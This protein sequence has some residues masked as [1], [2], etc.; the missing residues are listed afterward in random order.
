MDLLLLI[1][2]AVLF[3]GIQ[4]S[5][6]NKDY[7]GRDTTTAIKGIF[8]IIILFSHSRQY[9]SFSASDSYGLLNDYN[10]LYTIV[11]N[12][13]GQLMVVMF[14]L[15]SGYGIVESYKKKGTAYKKGF[16]RKRVLK[17]LVHF[18]VAVILFLIL[19]FCIGREYDA[20]NIV[21]SFTGWQ[22]VG[23]SNWFVF[24]II[25]LYLV[26]YFG[27]VIVE[28]YKKD[29]ECYLWIVFVTTVLFLLVLYFIKSGEQWWYDTVLAFPTGMLWSVYKNRIEQF[30][31]PTK[32]YVCSLILTMIIF[33]ILYYVS[34]HY[35]SAVYILT[36]A[37]F[38]LMLILLTMKLKVG[39]PVLHWLGLNA[40]AIYIL[41]R[42]PMIIAAEYG[43]NKDHIIFALTVIPI[44]LI[45][46]YGFTKATDILDR[47][48]FK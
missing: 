20:H 46:A 4:P 30:L 40:F 28:R 33:S 24:D 7:L 27:L 48:F 13:I 16:L 10:Y 44:T 9:L 32:V 6:N 37:V 22:S 3:F 17:T 21:L 23:N 39:N 8:A 11:L 34:L 18:D 47:K 2:L 19:A 14:L 42:I 12:A 35:V 43:L 38:G 26:S 31:R 41:Q 15:Y 5:K 45:L 36:S 1:F 29:I 25:I